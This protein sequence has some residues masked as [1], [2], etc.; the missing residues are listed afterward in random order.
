MKIYPV[1]GSWE[2]GYPVNWEFIGMV[3]FPDGIIE[4]PQFVLID[5]VRYR[6]E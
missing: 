1:D 4:Q 3:S 2:E 5:G 6:K